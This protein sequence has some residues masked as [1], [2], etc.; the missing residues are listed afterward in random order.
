MV[1]GNPGFG[2]QL[3]FGLED[4]ECTSPVPEWLPADRWEDLLAFSILPGSLEGI[5]AKVANS[6]DLWRS[7]YENAEPEVRVLIFRQVVNSKFFNSFFQQHVMLP[8]MIRCKTRSKASVRF[9]VACNDVILSSCSEV[10][11]ESPANAFVAKS[12]FFEALDNFLPPLTHCTGA[13][14]LWL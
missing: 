7:W 12:I 13:V 9:Y 1:H 11:R 5:C 6:S 3:P 14:W 10:C 2:K 4:F 8:V